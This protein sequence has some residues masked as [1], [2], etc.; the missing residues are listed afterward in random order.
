MRR[1]QT[2][3]IRAN[4]RICSAGRWPIN[5]RIQYSATVTEYLQRNIRA[6]R[7]THSA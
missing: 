7:G 1:V 5:K 2:A 4:R 3:S 6:Q